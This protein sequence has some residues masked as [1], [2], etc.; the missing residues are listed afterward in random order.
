MWYALTGESF[1]QY[2]SASRG[3]IEWKVTIVR[4]HNFKREK[5]VYR[6]TVPE[7][8][9]SSTDTF[10]DILS[11]GRS[12]LAEAREE[13]QS[14][15]GMDSVPTQLVGAIGDLDRELDELDQNLEVAEQDIQLAEETTKRTAILA[16][17]LTVIKTRQQIIIEGAVDRAEVFY[18]E[19]EKLAGKYDIP[20]EVQTSLEELDHRR[21]MVKKLVAGSRYKQIL[22]NDQVTPDS[23]EEDLHQLTSD[24]SPIT[25][26]IDR[27]ET[28]LNI[29]ENLL[30]DIHDR[31]GKLHE[32][33]GDRMA[34]STELQEIKQ[35]QQSAESNLGDS[36]DQAV[37]TAE[38]VLQNCLSLHDQIVAAH[39]DQHLTN[40][41]AELCQGNALE[42]AP[43]IDT[44]IAEG[45]P[46]KLLSGIADS[47]A[48]QVDLSTGGRLQQLL[49]EHDGSVVRTSQSTDFDV[50][51]IMEHITQLYDQGKVGEIQVEFNE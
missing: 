45:D 18:K 44:C 13:Y 7:Q 3:Q 25:T 46:E 30:N 35:Q 38:E 1:C 50:P 32:E 28:Y 41:L 48:S 26:A 15:E 29:C 23:F 47:I 19:I 2:L 4:S 16:E 49:E 39:A 22:E 20:D 27:T 24:L 9:S 51:T 21:S 17:V 34:F 12:Q 40:N 14:L 37:D 42:I 11:S 33:N 43:D 6:I 31:L 10:E 5:Y 36:A 8:P